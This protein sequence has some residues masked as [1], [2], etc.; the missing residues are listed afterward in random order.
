[1]N[2]VDDEGMKPLFRFIACVLS[3]LLPYGMFVHSTLLILIGIICFLYFVVI[4]IYFIILHII[5][6][7][8]LK[9]WKNSAKG[10]EQGKT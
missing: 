3:F 10:V 8:T 1:M 5:H 2:F 7:R 4:V 9:K 6:N